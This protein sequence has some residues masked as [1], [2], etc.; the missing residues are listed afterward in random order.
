MQ[1]C[2]LPAL[3]A[4]SGAHQGYP[5]PAPAEASFTATQDATLPP[6]QPRLL[7]A[8]PTDLPAS[9][10]QGPSK[11]AA[12]QHACRPYAALTG[13]GLQQWCAAAAATAAVA[14]IHRSGSEAARSR[15]QQSVCSYPVG[16]SGGHTTSA[17]TSTLSRGGWPGGAA[18]L[19][20]AVCGT[21]LQRGRRA[22]ARRGRGAAAAT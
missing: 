4:S 5:G 21:Y 16:R 15:L 19:S 2:T 11:S 3:P 1:P 9:W 7:T 22:G 8:P 6:Q 10:I 13:G 17:R 12:H 14:A 18:G 20:N